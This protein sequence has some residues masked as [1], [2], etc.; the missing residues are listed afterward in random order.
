MDIVLQSERYRV[1]EIGVARKPRDHGR[2]R[3]D[4]AC[5]DA[6]GTER[7]VLADDHRAGRVL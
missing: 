5:P 1:L 7:C 2:R 3:C 4:V 6:R